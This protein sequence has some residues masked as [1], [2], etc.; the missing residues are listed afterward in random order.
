MKII[1]GKIEKLKA[2]EPLIA[3]NCIRLDANESY[4]NLPAYLNEKIKSAVGG[5]DFNRYPDPMATDLCEKI[6]DF[7]EISAENIV[8]GNGSDEIISIIINSLCGKGDKVMTFTDDFSM[9]D[10]YARVAELDIIKCQKKKLEVDIDEV[11]GMAQ[12]LAPKII[13]FSNPCNPTGQGICKKDIEKLLG[14]DSLII[15]DE[16]YMEFWGTDESV[17]QQINKYENLI[18][19]K[20]LS[21]AIGLAALRCGFAVANKT[22]TDA[23]KKAKSPY[24]LNAITQ[25][26][27]EIIMEQPN[28]IHDCIKKILDNKSKLVNDLVCYDIIDTKTNFIVLKADNTQEIYD[29]LADNGIY[30]RRFPDFLRITVGT[31]EE[32]DKL[33][34]VLGGVI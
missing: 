14:L 34:Q 13:I 10:F 1:P 19:L 18:V 3:E 16:A 20:T 28:Y 5:I 2:Y 32:N 31:T 17:L 7:Y 24:N 26:T 30:V 4:F 23:L 29:R 25:R 21:K 11:I 9:Y 27:A 12:E 15:V 33:V 8:C 22:I 6:S